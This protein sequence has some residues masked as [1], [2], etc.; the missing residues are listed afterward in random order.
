DLHL[1][2][3]GR[4][5]RIRGPEPPVTMTF[6]ADLDR[7]LTEAA[8]AA[9]ASLLAPCRVL[10]VEAGSDR[11]RLATT[12][13]PLTASYLVAADGAAGQVARWAGLPDGR[14]LVP[15]L[16]SEI[17]VAPE[18]HER[19]ADSARFDF[20]PVPAGY[21]W[22][23]PKRCGLSVGCLTTRPGR[24]SLRRGLDLYLG[25]LGLDRPRGRDDH[26]FVIPVRPR[27]EVA[28]G[29]VLAVGDAAGLADPVTCE[30]ISAAIESGRLAARAILAH[31]GPAA[32]RARYRCELSAGLLPE[33]ARA[34]LLARALYGAPPLRRLAFRRLG[35]PLAEAVGR[36]MAGET[37]YRRLGASPAGLLRLAARLAGV[38][39]G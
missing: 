10:G 7:L 12:A 21:A 9:G 19:Y 29:R 24:R 28:R 3:L 22:V 1:H 8:T 34:R 5:F 20:G 32:V 36:V 33:L 14:L 35:Q 26:G 16:E 2:D 11:A 37:T 15:A 30:G 25:L 38:A 6:R 39:G 23:F 17:A 13:G 18:L 27:R 31:A 4:R